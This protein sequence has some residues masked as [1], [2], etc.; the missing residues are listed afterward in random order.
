[1]ATSG[2]VSTCGSLP[3]SGWASGLSSTS[4]NE[5]LIVN[6]PIMSER[7]YLRRTHGADVSHRGRP[8]EILN[9]RPDAYLWGKAS[10]SKSTS[11]GTQ[12]LKELPPRF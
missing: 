3:G 10:A 7:L 1:M 9:L 12:H 8:A 6:G 11:I 5:Q 2:Y 4:C